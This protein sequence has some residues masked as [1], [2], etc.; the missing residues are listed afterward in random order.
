MTSGLP[1]S[2]QAA[3]HDAPLSVSEG[4]Y[5]IVTENFPDMT[6]QWICRSLEHDG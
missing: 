5:L 3:L 2:S 1:E 6:F 4:T